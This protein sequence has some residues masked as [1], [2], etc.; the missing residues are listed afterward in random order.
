MNVKHVTFIQ[1]EYDG[2]VGGKCSGGNTPELDRH[3]VGKFGSGRKLHDPTGT[4][5]RAATVEE[6]VGSGPVKGRWA[7]R[8]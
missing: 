6:A 1:A 3:A 4:R 8:G 5:R 7:R 2:S